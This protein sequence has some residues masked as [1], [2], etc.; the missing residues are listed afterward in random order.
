M[1]AMEKR[2]PTVFANHQTPPRL[3]DATNDPAADNPESCWLSLAAQVP[4][5]P[6]QKSRKRGDHLPQLS[7]AKRNPDP[8]RLGGVGQTLTGKPITSGPE[9]QAFPIFDSATQ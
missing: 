7:D 3:G 8:G 6:N 4:Y 9:D 1:T 2:A 5:S